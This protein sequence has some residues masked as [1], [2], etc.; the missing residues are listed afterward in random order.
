MSNFPLL[1]R[2]IVIVD[3]IMKR[4]IIVIANIK[5]MEKLIFKE[6]RRSHEEI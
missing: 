1:K 3:I 6:E 5:M 4:D 2:V